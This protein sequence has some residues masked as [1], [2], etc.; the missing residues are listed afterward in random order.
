LTVDDVVAEFHVLDAL[1]HEQSEGAG[2][3]SGLAPAAENRQS[4]GGFKAPLKSDD[5]LDVCAVLGTER[6]LDI[7]TDLIQRQCDRFDVSVTQMRVFS[8]FGDG[9]AASRP[10]WA[11]ASRIA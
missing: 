5:A 4:G 8:Y 2:R 7:A 9:D 10:N 1:G 3:P 11:V 6:C